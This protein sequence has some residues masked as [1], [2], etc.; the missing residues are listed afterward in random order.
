[1]CF[2]LLRE[3]TVG[4]VLVKLNYKEWQGEKSERFQSSIYPQKILAIAIIVSES[5][6]R[7]FAF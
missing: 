4:S 2:S 7:G 5:C 6:V 1:M 3:S